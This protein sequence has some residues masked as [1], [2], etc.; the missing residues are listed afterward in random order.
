[1]DSKY[2]LSGAVDKKISEWEVPQCYV[3]EDKQA[4]H[5][6]RDTEFNILAIHTVIRDACLKGELRAAEALL[7]R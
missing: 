7:T 5:Q 2:V 1:M 6:D 3:P 4:P